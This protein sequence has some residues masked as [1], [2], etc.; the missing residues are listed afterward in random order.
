M[1]L[2]DLRNRLEGS[3]KGTGEF[4]GRQTRR[5]LGGQRPGAARRI[6]GQWGKE[7]KKGAQCECTQRELV[8]GRAR[9]SRLGAFLRITARRG[10]GEVRK[11]LSVVNAGFKD[12]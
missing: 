10:G 11:D 8:L 1:R 7:I 2:L 12:P 4:A 9:G 5:A 3:P 6:S